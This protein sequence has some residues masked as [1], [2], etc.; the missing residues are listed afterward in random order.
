VAGGLAYTL[1]VPFF[2]LDARLRYSHFIWHLFVLTGSGCH[3]AAV[4]GY[5]G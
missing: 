5:G 1:G 2:A 3:V 4:L